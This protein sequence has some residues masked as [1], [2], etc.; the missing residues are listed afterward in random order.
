MPPVDQAVTMRRQQDFAPRVSIALNVR[1]DI[2]FIVS[3][4]I[5][6]AIQ[7][8]YILAN[9]LLFIHGRFK[10]LP[11]FIMS[12]FSETSREREKVIK[13]N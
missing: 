1:T 7:T 5:S 11:T 4:G 9:V 6:V 8:F 10:Q 12:V 3:L 13:T 2:G